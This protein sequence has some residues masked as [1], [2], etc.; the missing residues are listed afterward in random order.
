MIIA[1]PALCAFSKAI[2]AYKSAASLAK[3][4]VKEL[5][6]QLAVRSRKV[7]LETMEDF[8]IKAFKRFAPKIIAPMLGLAASAIDMVLV[9][10][11]NSFGSIIANF[12]DKIDGRKDGYI[13]G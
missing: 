13:F 1:I 2:K 8:L 10:V 4:A 9:V 5:V 6:D 11:G 12:L 7:I 3:K